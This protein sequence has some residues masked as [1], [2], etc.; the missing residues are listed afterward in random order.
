MAVFFIRTL[1][2]YG[3]IGNNQIE[4]PLKERSPIPC[5]ADKDGP[6]ETVSP[7]MMRTKLKILDHSTYKPPEHQLEK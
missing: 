7:P 1:L 4:M 6:I 5:D 3:C 2:L